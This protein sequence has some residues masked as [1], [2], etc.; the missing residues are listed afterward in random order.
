MKVQNEAIKRDLEQI[1]KIKAK[2]QYKERKA[3]EMEIQLMIAARQS[4]E[5]ARIREQ[6]N[7]KK[8]EA[9]KAQAEEQERIRKQKAEERLRE[10]VAAQ[11]EMKRLA[12]E[13]QAIK[14][15][16]EAER[17]HKL[18]EKRLVE[19]AER[20]EAARLA[21]ERIAAVKLLEQEERQQVLVNFEAA[22]KVS[23]EKLARYSEGL[24]MKRLEA[25]EKGESKQRELDAARERVQ[26]AIE[27][28]RR[29]AKEKEQLLEARLREQELQ[30]QDAV[31]KKAAELEDKAREQHRKKEHAKELEVERVRSIVQKQEEAATVLERAKKRRED[32]LIARAEA[33]KKKHEDVDKNVKTMQVREMQRIQ[34]LMDTTNAK[35]ARCEDFI[36]QRT[37]LLGMRSK[38]R[39]D[40]LMQKMGWSLLSTAK[41]H[42]QRQQKEYE[43]MKKQMEES[44]ESRSNTAPASTG[45][46]TKI[47]TAG[48]T[49]TGRSFAGS[50]PALVSRGSSGLPKSPFTTLAY[51]VPDR[52]M[53]YHSN[54]RERFSNP[55][56][57]NDRV[58][59]VPRS[60]DEAYSAVSTPRSSTHK[61]EREDTAVSEQTGQ[62]T[63]VQ[64]SLPL[65]IEKVD[66]DHD[67]QA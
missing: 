63:E 65:P 1:E 52:P 28:A 58:P 11:E 25:K 21:A 31:R 6:E 55:A 35:I 43:K 50:L 14:E 18:E 7:E 53:R 61:E 32:E 12:L 34:A 22:M 56:I 4:E 45:V 64:N 41:A 42:K 5:K 2:Q 51:K 67:V 38:M 40:M 39:H 54:R 10:M 9:R 29:D 46:R 33:L 16:R 44:V 23:E 30:R 60:F 37:E 27:K 48:S 8:K 15:A 3:Q 26:V 49:L 66:S 19:S 57:W 20:A 13:R 62:S 36:E 24:A 17:I 59:R 47:S